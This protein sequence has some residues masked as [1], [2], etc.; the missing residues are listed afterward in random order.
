MNSPKYIHAKMPIQAAMWTRFHS[1][2]EMEEAASKRT[3]RVRD[4]RPSATTPPGR[5]RQVARRKL[6]PDRTN[7]EYNPD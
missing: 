6:P 2:G 3:G 4:T 5:Q 7:R 1:M